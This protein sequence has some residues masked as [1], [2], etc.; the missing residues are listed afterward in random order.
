MIRCI[1]AL[2]RRV[3]LLITLR[4]FRATGTISVSSEN[5][6]EQDRCTTS[7]PLHGFF[8]M[9]EAVDD[10]DALP[11]GAAL[12]GRLLLATACA[13]RHRHAFGKGRSGSRTVALI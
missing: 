5:H 1:K 3:S 6:E 7:V 11:E 13:T 4:I 10:F 12:F 9:E 2:P 8:A